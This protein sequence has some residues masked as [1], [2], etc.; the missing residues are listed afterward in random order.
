MPILKRAG[1]FE[2]TSGRVLSFPDVSV[3]ETAAP[4][5]LSSSSHPIISCCRAYRLFFENS[6]NIGKRDRES[7]NVML[8]NFCAGG[9]S[10]TAFIFGE[11]KL[12][13]DHVKARQSGPASGTRGVNQMPG[14]VLF[15]IQL[16][17]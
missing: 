16:S 5:L 13:L 9:P 4:S 2:V 10:H 15:C 14:R 1:V 12:E 3:G 17:S 11:A 8:R 6:T 7:H